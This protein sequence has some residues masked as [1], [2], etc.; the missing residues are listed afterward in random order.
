MTTTV[1]SKQ[2]WL[3]WV[4]LD[5]GAATAIYNSLDNTCCIGQCKNAHKRLVGAQ[6]LHYTASLT[7]PE[8]QS[9]WLLSVVLGWGL[10]FQWT[11]IVFSPRSQLP[12]EQTTVKPGFWLQRTCFCT[13]LYQPCFCLLAYNLL[14]TTLHLYSLFKCLLVSIKGR[15]ERT[16]SHFLWPMTLV[17]KYQ[18][19]WD[20]EK[21]SLAQMSS[22]FS[23]P[24]SCAARPEDIQQTTL[25]SSGSAGQ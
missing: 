9:S 14:N 13:C 25:G 3:N 7:Q 18:G 5:I 17:W 1:F 24:T 12:V 8:M 11:H 10:N 21:I 2:P 6:P 4:R 16:F 22:K 23:T 20:E 15:Q 19:L